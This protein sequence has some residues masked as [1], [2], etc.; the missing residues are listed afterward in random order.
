METDSSPN[1]TGGLLGVLISLLVAEKSGFQL[2][3]DSP[4][5]ND[6]RLHAEKLAAEATAS[7]KQAEKPLAKVQ[8][9]VD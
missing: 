1:A 5:L 8:S 3:V 2:G 9:Q 7:E 4:E 6:L